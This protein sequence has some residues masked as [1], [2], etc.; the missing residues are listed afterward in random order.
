[1]KD[2][3]LDIE[4]RYTKVSRDLDTL[5]SRFNEYKGLQQT[6]NLKKLRKDLTNLRD[7]NIFKK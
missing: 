3:I 7:T 2:D 5:D 6:K 1:M 4:K